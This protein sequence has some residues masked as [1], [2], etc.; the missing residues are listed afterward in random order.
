M[1]QSNEWKHQF[2]EANGIRIHYMTAG[3]GE[4]VLLLHGFPQFWYAWRRQIPELAKQFKVIVPDLRGYGQTDKPSRVEDYQPQ[5]IALDIV[6]LIHALGYEKVHMVG[7]D[8][9]GAIGWQIALNHP[10]V[11]NKLAILNCPH[12]AAFSKALK[13]NFHQM[14]KS[15]YIYFFQLPYIPE[16][17][18]K[19]FGKSLFEL[20]MRR[21]TS[22]KETFSDEDLKQ[23]LKA[24]QQP[25]VST[26][27]FNYYR[28]VFRQM[29]QTNKSKEK[30]KKIK[31]PT[32]LI[33]GEQDS[34]FVKEL[35]HD[36][37][38]FFEGPFELRYI[39]N[40]SH[41]VNEEQPEV[42]NQ[43]LVHHFHTQP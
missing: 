7:H 4:P 36:M 34:A 10:E 42:V 3:E 39:P 1:N 27:A 12:P 18:F 2:I 29:A 22:R 41:W 33:W 38:C 31:A 20:M 14:A 25:G 15:W 43:L 23:Y 17:T 26:A 21:N 5:T 37:Q 28:A 6:K 16:W 32:L 30:M 13:S 8:W 24:F 19:I 35:T 40:C 9:G 11:V